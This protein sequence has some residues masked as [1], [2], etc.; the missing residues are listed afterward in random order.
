MSLR[1]PEDYS[2]IGLSKIITTLAL[3]PSAPGALLC[4]AA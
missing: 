3:R 1:T 4:A 2:E